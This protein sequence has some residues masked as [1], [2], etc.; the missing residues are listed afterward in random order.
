[1]RSLPFIF[2]CDGVLVDSEVIY[3][4][5]D[6]H[7]LAEIGLIYTDDAY[8]KRFIGLTDADFFAT[9]AQDYE[10]R[11]LGTFPT[12]L[13]ARMM[14]L[15]EARIKAELEPVPD[16]LAFVQSLKGPVA[17]ASS[18]DLE[19]LHVKLEKTGLHAAFA[20]HIYSGQ[21]VARG[22]P[23]P[24]LFLMA[25]ERLGVSPAECIV[26]EDSVNGVRAA[27]AAGRTAWGF[28]GGGHALPSLADD[29]RAAGAV[30][31]FSSFVA[32]GRTVT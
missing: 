5:V 6:R 16:G 10:A 12:S 21:M 24:D 27:R 1:M 9:L 22:K 3:L 8:A 14:A 26:I 23:A 11:G 32:M 13:P 15:S 17:V 4:A 30:E 25:A 19:M 20:P 28:T 31:V 18:S 29:L 7:C 2:D